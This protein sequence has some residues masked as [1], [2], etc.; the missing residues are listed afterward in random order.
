[1]SKSFKKSKVFRTWM[2]KWTIEQSNE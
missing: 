2:G 1:M